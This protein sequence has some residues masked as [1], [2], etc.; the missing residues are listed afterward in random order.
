M[1]YEVIRDFGV[2]IGGKHYPHGAVIN[3]DELVDPATVK[4]ATTSQ[5]TDAQK[6]DKH[7]KAVEAKKAVAAKDLEAAVKAGNQIVQT[8]PPEAASAKKAKPAEEKEA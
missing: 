8:K 2:D 1:F 4:V 7:E 5:D 3:T 6:K